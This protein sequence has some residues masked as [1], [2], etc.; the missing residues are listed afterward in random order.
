MVAAATIE[1]HNLDW[2]SSDEDKTAVT[3]QL[4][5]NP[6]ASRHAYGIVPLSMDG[7]PIYQLVIRLK[8]I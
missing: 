5:T 1:N 6:S 2:A 4:P 7:D 3:A 8:V